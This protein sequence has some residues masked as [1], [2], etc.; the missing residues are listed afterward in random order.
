M[1]FQYFTFFQYSPN[2]ANPSPTQLA[3]F[4][5]HCGAT[6]SGWY[7]PEGVAASNWGC[8]IAHRTDPKPP[9]YV[10]PQT[11][12]SGPP[13][14]SPMRF[15]GASSPWL[16]GGRQQ[17]LAPPHEFMPSSSPLFRYDSVFIET[18]NSHP[19][20]TWTA[21]AHPHI[22]GRPAHHVLK[23]LGHARKAPLDMFAPGHTHTR[24]TSQRHRAD[25]RA[26]VRGLPPALNWAT[27]N[28]GMYATPVVDQGGCGSCWAIAATDTLTMRLL[29]KGKLAQG[30]TLAPQAALSCSVYN[31]ACDGGYPLLAGAFAVDIGYVTSSCLPY[32]PSRPVCPASLPATCAAPTVVSALLQVGAHE[33]GG[34]SATARTGVEAVAHRVGGHSG[35]RGAAHAAAQNWAYDESRSA[36][37]TSN[38]G[39]H[40]HAKSYNYV[41]GAYGA[42]S[43]DA[44]IV[45][46]QQGPLAVAFNAPSSLTSYS[47]GIYN[48]PDTWDGS[49]SYVHGV[50]R[51]LKTNHAVVLVGYGVDARHGPYWVLKN[52][53]GASWG[54]N[55]YFK[56][57]RVVDD[58]APSTFGGL[59]GLQSMAVELVV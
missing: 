47:R 54:A 48:L 38:A 49:T 57:G 8:F 3:D 44:M 56:V 40:Y 41:G 13:V 18:Q 12:V 20:S 53:W 50:S 19:T 27:V 10:V 5:S 39:S 16:G 52:S 29:I 15:R 59:L 28:G 30:E 51:W 37:Y 45:A 46:L 2:T 4:T 26:Q 31:Q 34:D 1:L 25:L 35:I 22:D 23:M 55:G 43:H 14:L 17:A 11:L 33:G 58:S 32:D 24:F 6:F 9:V 21:A 42:C 36:A 7:K